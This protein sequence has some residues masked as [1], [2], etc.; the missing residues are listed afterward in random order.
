[1]D[2]KRPPVNAE[3]APDHRKLTGKQA[4]RLGALADIAHKELAGLTVAEV[5]EK[6]KWRVDPELLFFRKIC[7]KVVKK[8]PVTGVEYPVPFAT[9]AVED[10]DCSLLGYFPK[11]WPWGWFFPL[12]CHRE[13]LATV[14]TDKCGNFCAWIPRFDIDWILRWRK[15]RVCFPWIFLRPSIPDLVPPE[16][17]FPIPERPFPPRPGPGPDPGPLAGLMRLPVSTVE[18]LSG[19]V[20]R[21][22]AQRLSDFQVTQ[23]LGAPVG[24]LEELSG[25]RAFETELPPPLPQEF[26]RVLA[27]QPDVGAG[28]QANVHDAVRSAVALELG[29]EAKHLA[30]LDLNR[31][32][33]P[34]LRCFDVYLP[35]WQLIL[36]VPD[37]TFKVTQD[38]D[39]DGVEETIYTEGYFDVRWNAGPIPNVKLVA[40]PIAKESHLC[41]TPDV[42]CGNV[43]AILFAGLMP[44]TDASYFDVSEGYAKRPNRPMPAGPRPEAKTP[45]LW[46]LQLY[47][48][49]N[50]SSASY[51]RVLLSSDNGASFSAMTGLHWNIY[52]IPVGPPLSVASDK[53]G[54]YPV[55][56]NPDA[57]HPARMVIEWPTPLLGKYVL[58]VEVANAAKTV[59]QTSANV[60]IQV[61]NTAP[62]VIFTTLKWKFATEP[63]SA[64]N[65][66]GRNL[67]VTCPTI[68]RGVTPKDVDVQFEATVS[69]NHL[70]DGY[71]YVITCD[72][73]A[74]APL[75][76][77]APHTSHWHD[78]VTDNSEFLQG[79]YRIPATDLEGAYTFGCRTNSRAMN[80]A[81]GDGG[82]LVDWFYD[83]VYVYVQPE[84]R[85]AIING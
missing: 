5:G 24:S 63:D 4:T 84:I 37:I 51:Y 65:L 48:C 79:R 29:I 20:G 28:R 68:R 47:G 3:I 67:L 59:L 33:G 61:D 83:P 1:M 57:Y 56:S 44:L 15:Q 41:D 25:A 58:K 42:P 50:I 55:L 8:D 49:V 9:V 75:A 18:A 32:I 30:H 72:G 64:F 21:Q 76:L 74:I 23:G 82:H 52:P 70:R 31:Y 14:K 34:F 81:G 73:A 39:G 11:S 7:G 62:T 26:R 66:S 77:P 80:P 6:L 19:T 36:D 46:T 16:E 60:A 54:W 69:A 10:T 27:G 78:A 38:V 53:D 17:L 2:K 85:V 40:S 12:S 71:I 43:P 13:T 45:F 35:Q 22:L